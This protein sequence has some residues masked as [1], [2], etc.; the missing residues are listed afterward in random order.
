MH[1]P[2]FRTSQLSH[3]DFWAFGDFG[4]AIRRKAAALRDRKTDFPLLCIK[5]TKFVVKIP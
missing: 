5:S 1:K 2:T 3:Y 4:L